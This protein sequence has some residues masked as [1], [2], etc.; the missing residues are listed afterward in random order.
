MT[1]DEPTSRPP[2]AQPPEPRV[3]WTEYALLLLLATCWGATYPLT[4]IALESIPPL[5]F[6][7]WRSAIAA[8]ALLPIMAWRR[9][10][11]PRDG[12]SW[13]LLTMTQLINSTVPFV[14]LTWAQLYV[15]ASLTVVLA[16]TTPIWGFLIAWAVT[17]HEPATGRKLI[18]VLLGF[19]G[20]AVVVGPDALTG[21]GQNLLPQA[22]IL[23]ATFLFAV[24]TIYGRRLKH[25]DPLIVSTASSLFGAVLLLPFSL[26][27]EAPWTLRPTA[28]AL[29]ALIILALTG[30]ALGLM[31]FYRLV[32]TVGPIATNSSSYLRIPIGIGLSVLVVGESL[33]P[34]LL[35]GVVL[36]FLGVFAMTVPARRS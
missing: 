17:R 14:L 10:T 5:T 34:S 15:P 35:G 19:A 21:L 32:N 33:P 18:G 16:A 1:N 31:L 13:H 20:A 3:P 29:I 26:A 24:G 23:A 27:L 11:F 36:V 2:E 25:I 6:M 12:G 7:C 28:S 4:K 8:A 30:T 9:L 22:A